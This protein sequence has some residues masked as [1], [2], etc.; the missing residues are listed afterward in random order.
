ISIVGIK[1]NS[2]EYK[3]SVYPNPFNN[4]TIIKFENST[5]AKH[6]LIIFDVMGHIVRSITDISAGQIKIE[7][8]SLASGLYFF[9]L[10]NEGQKVAIGKL[11][12]Q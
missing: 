3:V 12:I 9:Q 10:Q 11:M 8:K 4:H 1:D 2:S 6:D 7:R 5:E